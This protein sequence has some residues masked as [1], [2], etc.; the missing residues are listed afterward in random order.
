[1]KIGG[2]IVAGGH[3]VVLILPR[4][5]DDQIVIRA[6]AVTDLDTF[7]TICPEPKP[8]GKLTKN[9]WEP[10]LKDENY[11]IVHSRHLSQRIAYLVIQ[12]LEPSKIEWDT[13]DINNPRTWTNYI[14]DFKSAGLTGIEI[15]RIIGAV[16][17]ANSLD[18]VKLE[19]AREIFLRGQ[20]LEQENSSSQQVELPTT[21]SGEPAQDLA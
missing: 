5:T 20:R 6:Q 1:M 18:E 15:N 4:G 21:P 9:G 16:M 13:T 7:Y 10:N 19:Q 3:E 14:D 8:P 11:Q 2:K 12:S 17:E